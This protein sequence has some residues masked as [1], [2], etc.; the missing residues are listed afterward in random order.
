MGIKDYIEQLTNEDRCHVF[1]IQDHG[2]IL[3]FAVQYYAKID[4]IWRSIMRVD[5]YHGTPHR[6][7]Y[8]LHGDESRVEL[9]EDSNLAFTQ[10][11][12]EIRD[13]FLAIKD[14]FLFSQ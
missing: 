4:G 12:A 2:K 3:K 8:Y 14:N 13:N 6:H 9:L 11:K 5:N 7:T 10:A 1:F